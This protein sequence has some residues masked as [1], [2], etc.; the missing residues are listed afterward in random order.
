MVRFCWCAVSLYLSNTSIPCILTIV[1]DKS[2]FDGADQRFLFRC[3]L[4][5]LWSA[6]LSLF[7][8]ARSQFELRSSKLSLFACPHARREVVR[9]QVIAASDQCQSSILLRITRCARLYSQWTAR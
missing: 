3:N 8:F 4:Y 7:F 9:I 2:M 1:N 5:V 6:N